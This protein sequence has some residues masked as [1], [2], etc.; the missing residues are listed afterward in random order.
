ML[1]TNDFFLLYPSQIEHKR[2]EKNCSQKKIFK[3]CL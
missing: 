1:I 2:L 3:D